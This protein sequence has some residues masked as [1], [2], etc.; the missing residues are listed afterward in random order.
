MGSMDTTT[1]KR[2]LG[3]LFAVAVANAVLFLALLGETTGWQGE[4][5]GVFVTVAFGFAAAF[6]VLTLL[7][8]RLPRTALVVAVLTICAY[9]T[10]GLPSVGVVLPLLVV[11]AATT[12]AGHRTFALV[13]MG[14]LFVVASFFRIRGGDSVESVLG[15]ELLSNVVLVALAVALAEVIRT[16]RELQATQEHSTRMAAEA[17]RAHAE[18]VQEVDRTRIARELHDELGHSLAIV[19]LHANAVSEQVPAD[20]PA[21]T[22]AHH[23]RDAASQALGQLRRAVRAVGAPPSSGA[24]PPEAARV[25]E[26]ADS[27]QTAAAAQIETDSGSVDASGTSA[28]DALDTVVERIRAGGVSVDVVR[29]HGTLPASV[30]AAAF[31]IVQETTTNALRHAEPDH[32]GIALTTGPP[33]GSA[34]GAG[35]LRIRV[36]NDGACA[37]AGTDATTGDGTTPVEPP[38][39][40]SSDGAST[41]LTGLAMRAAELGGTLTWRTKDPDL[42]VV[43]AVLPLD[44]AGTRPAGAIS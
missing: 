17:A 15:Y 2:V 14:I 5:D 36:L 30:A 40:G 44:A 9:Y 16:R 7:R 37:G 23:L 29:D 32:I 43:D 27:A 12:V 8:D 20:H 33:V 35:D 25:S 39:T 42:F 21:L 1:R 13:T 28:L 6:G 19:S 31:R 3:V 11:L 4:R 22:S 38:S 26:G 41:G 24:R 34:E 18:R 10:V